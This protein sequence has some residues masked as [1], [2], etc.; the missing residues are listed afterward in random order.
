MTKMDELISW[1]N[2]AYAMEIS[3]IRTLE[4]HIK[5]ADEFPDMQQRLEEHLGE[6]R[7]HASRIKECIEMVGGKV[8]RSKAGLGELMGRFKG[9]STGMFNDEVVKDVL[10]DSATEHFEVACYRSLI[11]AAEQLGKSEIVSACRQNLEED[12]AMADWV[13]DKVP[14][15]T[16]RFMDT[17]LA[18]G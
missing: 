1:L 5:D 15:I 17:K 4:R 16:R 13:D 9:R 7:M 12:Q 3:N 18:A 14:E 10:S 2:D 8:S 6:T 11:A